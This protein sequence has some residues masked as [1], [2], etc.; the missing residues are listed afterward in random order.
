MND[1]RSNTAFVLLHGIGAQTHT[2]TIRDFLTCIEPSVGS[3]PSQEMSQRTPSAL[4]DDYAYVAATREHQ[5][6][7]IVVAEYY[8]ADLSRIQTGLFSVLRNFFNL[9]ADAPDIIYACLG[10]NSAGTQT[11]DY[12]ILRLLRAIIA[13][14]IWLIYFPIVALNLAY[15]VFVLDF[16]VRVRYDA[17]V[18]LNSPAD[19]NV[20]IAGMIALAAFAAIKFAGRIGSYISS[21]L[22]FTAAFAAGVSLLAAYRV[23]TGEGVATYGDYANIFNV[24]LNA[25][26]LIVSV[27]SLIYL[28]LLPVLLIFFNQRRRGLLL[29]FAVMF[30]VTRFWLVLI[31][32][33]WLAIL[34]TLYDEATYA[35]L[36]QQI[37]GPIRFLSIFW[38]EVIVIAATFVFALASYLLKSREPS[39]SEPPT[40]YPRL[41]AASSFPYVAIALSV[42]ALAAIVACS[43]SELIKDCQSW[44]CQFVYAATNAIVAN[45]ATLLFFGTLVVQFAH[46]GFEPV[47]DIVN[48]FKSDRGH[49]RV[50]PLAAITSIWTYA[51][52]GTQHFRGMLGERLVAQVD[53]MSARFGPFDRIVFVAHSLGSMM[54]LDYISSAHKGEAKSAPMEL[55]TMGSPLEYI[56][57]FY[58][59]HL[60]PAAASFADE[61]DLRWTNVYRA[62]DYV[63][64]H[65]TTTLSD[66]IEEIPLPPEGH[67]GYFSDEKVG[68]IIRERYF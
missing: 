56:F 45:A 1:S 68:Q 20:V 4:S 47:L 12:L 38:L 16:A 67:F 53:D 28:A 33:V 30:L 9:V 41:I 18:T 22:A 51:P 63:G 64:T 40:K 66:R 15:G 5:A 21:L 8:W 7:K 42:S 55:V 27:G 36:V 65:V 10:P 49:R 57:R 35:S 46:K 17:N 23:V 39:G 50:N 43:C 13:L 24:G 52:G 62:D 60:F 59:P 54:A 32:T 29:G 14:S 58:M 11:K 31:T 2:R 19:L 25:L 61:H 34:T 6:S 26:W 37:G 48:F 44:N 3:D